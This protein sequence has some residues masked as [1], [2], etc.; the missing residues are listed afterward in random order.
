MEVDFFHFFSVGTH[1][2]VLAP[3]RNR[4]HSIGDQVVTLNVGFMVRLQYN[5]KKCGDVL[6]ADLITTPELLE[7]PKHAAMSAAWFWYI[8]GLNALAD[9]GDLQA[10]SQK[11]NGGLN[12]YT[13]RAANYDRALKTVI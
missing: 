3:E 2:E 9:N 7:Q 1:H 10:I 6:G 11:I 12:D 5:Y 13:D 8:N 4:E